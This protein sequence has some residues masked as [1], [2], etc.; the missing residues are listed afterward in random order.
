MAE[1]KDEAA[2]TKA[3][4]DPDPE[5]THAR[6]HKERHLRFHPSMDGSVR[7]S[8]STTPEQSAVIQS[9]VEERLERLFEEARR[10]GRRES[11]DAYA[12]DALTGICSDAIEG[13]SSEAA[14]TSE[15]GE[16]FVV[17]P[18]RETRRSEKYLTLLRVDLEA[19]RRGAVEGEE[20]CEITGLGPI[21]V[22]VAR[23][24]LDDS[25][26]KLVITK[27]SDV[28]HVTHLGR[29]PNAAQKI[30]R[31]WMAP[32]CEITGCGRRRIQHDHDNPYAHVHCTELGNLNSLC[33]H[34]H[35]LKTRFGWRVLRNDDGT[36]VMVPP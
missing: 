17:R 12:M 13:T 20:L 1:L 2:R 15:D 26:L 11:R 28:A 16:L 27:G 19:L 35:D 29:G 25:I 31:T 6:V 22:S 36:V 8:G 21:P 23:E 3:A 18:N 14:A 30:A 33:P 7:L 10:E 5:A 24:L 4:A 34:H 9:A 32:L